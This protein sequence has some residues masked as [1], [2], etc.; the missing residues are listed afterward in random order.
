[1]RVQEYGTVLNDYFFG[2][3]RSAEGQ[4]AL[5]AFITKLANEASSRKSG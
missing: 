1:M 3:C 2:R 5:K 4:R